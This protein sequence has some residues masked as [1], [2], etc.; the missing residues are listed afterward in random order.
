MPALAATDLRRRSDSVVDLDLA[1]VRTKPFEHV[2]KESYIDPEIYAELV[3]SF[4]T[5]PPSTG[6]TGYSTYWGDEQY[7]RLM[8]ENSAWKALFNAFHSQQFIDYSIRQFADAYRSYGCVIDLTK[9]RYVPYVETRKDKEARH[10]SK[11][12]HEPHE[13]W[14]RVDIHQG[15]VGY[16]RRPHV[17]HRRR[18]ISMLIYLCD[19]DQNQMVGGDLVLH[20]GKSSLFGW[21]DLVVRPKHNRSVVFPCYANSIHS[22]PEIKSEKG[23]RNF[24]QITVSSSTDAW[25]P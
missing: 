1:P 22:V 12:E 11:V 7:D 24:L 5:C 6:P 8:A 25:S 20:R 9:A 19:A 15:L 18:L 3:R 21:G 16:T 14:V 2:L 4:P 13:L 10:I 23:P 17:D